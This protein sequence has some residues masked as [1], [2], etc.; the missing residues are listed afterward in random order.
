[1]ESLNQFEKQ[2]YL[3]IETVRKNGQAVKTPVWFAQDGETL[4]IW[5]QADSGK[6]KRI[7]RNS[8]VRVVPSTMAGE[9]VGKW[10]NATAS[11]DDSPEAIKYVSEKFSKKYG[12]QFSMFGL[13]GKARGAKYTTL[14][15]HLE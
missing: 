15:I 9:P 12:M 10:I 6:A 7:R 14:K 13:L 3:N 1:M 11:A 4:L 5:T 8:K 2:K